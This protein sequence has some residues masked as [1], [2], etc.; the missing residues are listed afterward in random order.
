MFWPGILGHLQGEFYNI[1]RRFNLTVR[2]S[3]MIKI[4]VV[5]NYGYNTIKL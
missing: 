3:H 1:Q 5:V 4:I 2:I